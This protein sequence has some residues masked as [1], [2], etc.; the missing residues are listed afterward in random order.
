MPVF[1]KQCYFSKIN[2]KI[3]KLEIIS[4]LK[5][6]NSIYSILAVAK[7]TAEPGNS[8][9]Q[10]LANSST[11]FNRA[12]FVRSTRTPKETTRLKIQLSEFLSMVACNGKGS[13]FAVF[14]C[15]QFSSPLHVTA[16]TLES[17]AVAPQNLT[18]ELSAMIYLFKAVSRLDLR[19]TQ[20]PFTS[21][22]HYTLKVKA[23]SVEQAQAKI[24]R[25]FAVLS[26]SLVNNSANMTACDTEQ[27]NSLPNA[28]SCGHNDLT[29]TYDANRKR[30]TSGLFLPKIH[31]YHGLTTPKIY[32]ELAVRA[33]PRNK[34]LS[35]NK[36][37]YS[38]VAVEPL[39][40]LSQSDKSFYSLTKTYDTMNKPTLFYK[41][42][43][44]TTSAI[45]SSPRFEG[46]QYA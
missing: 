17:L 39:S 26:V 36:G 34:A 6:Q 21:F 25:L 44:G 29:T 20:K 32:S 19:K 10:T 42:L 4:F 3:N 31:Q 5:N 1:I 14:Q 22:P 2:A 24:S 9:N 45:V 27:N 30:D 37:G 28:G 16:Q 23:D 18:L 33:T 35:T 12:F 15:S 46:V 43:I 11:P 41:A 40:H 38:Y 8:N 13:P 7:T